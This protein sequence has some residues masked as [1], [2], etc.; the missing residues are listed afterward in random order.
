MG[1][2]IIFIERKMKRE[3]SPWK[4]NRSINLPIVGKHGKRIDVVKVTETLA[5]ETAPYVGDQYLCT[6]VKRNYEWT[7]KRKTTN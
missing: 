4:E 5:L 2:Y 7:S 1:P 6:L 3:D